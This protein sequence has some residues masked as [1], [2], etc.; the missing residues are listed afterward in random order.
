VTLVFAL[1]IGSLY[2]VGVYL[3]LRRS[4]VK[5]LLGFVA[6]SGATNLLIFV[7]SGLV[8]GRTAIVR[9]DEIVPEPPYAD[10]LAQALILT[11]I[12]ISFGVLAYAMVLARRTYEAL[13]EDD[14]DALRETE[15]DD[16]A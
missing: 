15:E 14:L 4:Y 11:A 12:V 9:P 3:L 10:P 7:C 16:S 5:L 2:A 13:H 6:L 8:R 1:L